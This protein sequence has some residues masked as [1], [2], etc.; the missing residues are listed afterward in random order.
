MDIACKLLITAFAVAA[1][2]AVA[3]R[4]GR[5]VAGLL[6]GMPTVSGPA[7]AWA[8]VDHGAP[9]AAEAALGTVAGSALCALFG[10]GYVLAGDRGRVRALGAAI[11]AAFAALPV[12]FF[13]SDRSGDTAVLLCGSAAVGIVCWF[14]Q[15]L[16]AASRGAVSPARAQPSS[17][18]ADI[19]LTAIVSGSISALCSAASGDFGPFWIGVMA[20]PPLVAAAVSWNLHASG[21]HRAA[22]QVAGFMQG[23]ATGV[24]GRGVFA[25]ALAL[26]LVPAGA[27]TAVIAAT[28]SG[29]ATVAVL[30]RRG[31]LRAPLRA[32]TA[33]V[34]LRVCAAVVAIGLFLGRSHGG[35][36]GSGAVPAAARMR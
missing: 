5:G 10:V 33:G 36:P 35:Y 15:R 28:A 27:V 20:S 16:H 17:R 18:S 2:L 24:L 31:G 1:V 25:C 13:W 12:V 23:Y 26:L 19:A 8:A 7:L 4:L 6:A 29:C 34:A 11:A 21:D 32:A 14:A 9:F 30:G 22:A 3:R